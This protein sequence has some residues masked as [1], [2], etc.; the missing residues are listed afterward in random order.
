MVTPQVSS[1][2]RRLFQFLSVKVFST[3]HNKS[4]LLLDMLLDDPGRVRSQIKNVV[5][6]IELDDFDC[7]MVVTRK[8]II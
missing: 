7:N 6:Q 5:C 8:V 1:K 2:Y 3:N 4:S